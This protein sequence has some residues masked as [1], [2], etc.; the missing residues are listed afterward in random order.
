MFTSLYSAYWSFFIKESAYGNPVRS[1]V[2][3]MAGNGSSFLEWRTELPQGGKYEVWVYLP[4]ISRYKR[5]MVQIYEVRQGKWQ[6]TIEETDLF[7]GEWNLL[8]VF[9]C[10]AGECIVSLS[11]RGE[12]EQMICGDAVKWV[13]AQD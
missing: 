2:G 5:G 10:Q 7:Q 3:K 9:D 1:Y 13:P 8:G 11:D 12:K 4:F 6:E